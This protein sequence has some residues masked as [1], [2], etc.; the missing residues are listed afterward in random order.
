MMVL[1]V[2][3]KPSTLK[4]SFCQPKSFPGPS[5][6]P[7]C[8][9]FIETTWTSKAPKIVDLIPKSWVYGP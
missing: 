7:A 6:Y 4:L 5:T 8:Q 3:G 1:V 9:P 2:N